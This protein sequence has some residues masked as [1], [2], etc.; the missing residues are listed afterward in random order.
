MIGTG[1]AKKRTA[2][3]AGTLERAIE[4]F[5]RGFCFTRSFTHPYIAQRVGQAWRLADGPRKRPIYRAE[6]WVTHGLDPRAIDPLVR[7]HARGRFGICAIC[8]IDE[9]QDAL[10]TGF[11]EIGYRLR[12]TEPF[13]VHSLHRIPAPPAP[14][15]IVRVATPELAAQLGKAT[16]NRPL[17]PELLAEG[18]GL[19]QYAA[20]IG[21]EMV[22]WV[23]SIAAGPPLNAT[24]CASM[25]VMPQFRRRG[26]ARALLCR[27]LRDDRA[28]GSRA[29]VLL[30]SHVGAKLYP[31]VGYA[32]I[33]TLL[34]FKPRR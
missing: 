16:R 32:Q 29:A 1:V 6:E 2:E 28:A 34:M 7:K 14:A 23:R 3:E 8:G 27:M 20:I 10:R 5:A 19:R 26:I 4:V 25:Y 13:M 18:S 21:G 22:G 12:T 33:G 31:V 9:P 30:A 15:Q 24:W 17:S 11:K